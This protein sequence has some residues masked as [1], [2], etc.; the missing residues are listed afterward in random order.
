LRS[1]A[2]MP[3][4]PQTLTVMRNQANIAKHN[5]S[6]ELSQNAF[7]DEKRIIIKD[8]KHSKKEERFLCIGFDGIGI[9]TV[10]FTVRV[11]KIR[12]IGAGH[13]R[14]VKVT[15]TL[16]SNSVNFLNDMHK[17]IKLNIKQ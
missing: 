5:V 1:A 17:N 16:S 7:F 2:D 14:E 12:I 9:N 10:R 15:I 6:F 13:W 8:V 4:P 11:S 3:P